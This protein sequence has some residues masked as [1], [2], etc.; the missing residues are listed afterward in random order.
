LG[1]DYRN[2]VHEDSA[3]YRPVEPV[4]LVGNP[5]KARKQLGWAPD[6][7]F[8]ELVSKMVDAD[9]LMLGGQIKVN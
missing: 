7:G 9:L 6:V 3:A 5:E 2:Y 4:Q 1:L 8:R